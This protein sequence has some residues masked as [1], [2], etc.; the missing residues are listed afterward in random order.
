MKPLL[1][2]PQRKVVLRL[3]SG[4]EET[5][6]PPSLSA[7]EL[8]NLL[9]RARALGLPLH[10]DAQIAALLTSLRMS[11][12]VPPVLYNAAAA[13]LASVYAASDKA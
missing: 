12:D 9:E 5:P 13:V 6:T 10:H 11:K 4:A 7:D 1:P 8:E 2:A 3:S